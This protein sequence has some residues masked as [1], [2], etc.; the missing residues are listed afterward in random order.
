MDVLLSWFCTACTGNVLPF[1]SASLLRLDL[2]LSWPCM[3]SVWMDTAPS[4]HVPTNSDVKGAQQLWNDASCEHCARPS[5]HNHRLV[6]PQVA[7]D[8][9][10]AVAPPTGQQLNPELPNTVTTNAAAN[11]PP[12]PPVP[13]TPP[14]AP[15]TP[16]IIAPAP[17][18][19]PADKEPQDQPAPKCGGCTVS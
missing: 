12:A 3:P 4:V 15:P 13:H 8:P 11:T 18:A 9:P 7:Q 5:C 1:C 19:P 10:P 6:W 2:L 14:T 17:A 16:P